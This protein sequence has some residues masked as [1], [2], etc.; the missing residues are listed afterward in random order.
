M[1]YFTCKVENNNFI[2]KK[3]GRKPVFLLAYTR[4]VFS[5]KKS[6]GSGGIYATQHMHDEPNPGFNIVTSSKYLR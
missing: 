5:F 3:R 4:T 1:N 6:R 2:T